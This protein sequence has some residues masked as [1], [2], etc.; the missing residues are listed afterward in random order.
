M[1]MK[2]DAQNI[3]L[4]A[5]STPPKEG[6]SIDFS[7]QLRRKLQN[8]LERRNR[9]RFYLGWILI[10]T[11]T[12]PILFFS[13]VLIDA[14]YHTSTIAVITTHKWLFL[15]GFPLLFLIQYLDHTSIKQH[16]FKKMQHQQR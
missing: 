16:Q 11:V 4:T 13:L 3:L 7:S 8:Q 14:T 15:I 2:E 9:I 6:L 1:I 12:M 10:F 5:L